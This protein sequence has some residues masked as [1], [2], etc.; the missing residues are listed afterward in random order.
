MAKRDLLVS[1]SQM[2]DH[3]HEAISFADGKQREDLDVDRLL[4]LALIR[5]VE[6][7][8]EAAS[9]VGVE[10]RERYPQIPWYQVVGIRNRLIHGYDAI[11]LDILWEVLAK[12]LPTLAEDLDRIL[13]A[14]ADR[15]HE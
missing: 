13:D 6:I 3:A 9:R 12:D 11:D 4:T 1:L 10:D 5:L 15:G 7:V 14:A 2:R 8:G